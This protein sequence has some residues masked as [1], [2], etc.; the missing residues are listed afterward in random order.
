ML[1]NQLGQV[2]ILALSSVRISD[3][4]ISMCLGYCKKGSIKSLNLIQIIFKNLTMRYHF[5]NQ[6]FAD[7]AYF[8][9]WN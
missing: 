2:Q 1:W 8:I 7:F 9:V 3:N 4:Q 5:K 6:N